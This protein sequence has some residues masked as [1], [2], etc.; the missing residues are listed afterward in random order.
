MPAALSCQTLSL[1]RVFPVMV[2]ERARNAGLI[3]ALFLASSTALRSY[4]NG[5]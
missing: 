2:T 3:E 1:S 5:T 4:P